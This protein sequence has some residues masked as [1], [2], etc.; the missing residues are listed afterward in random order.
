MRRGFTLI[1]VLIVAA[2]ICL[3]AGLLFPVLGGAR[4][5]GRRLN[6]ASNLHQ[7]YLALQTYATANRDTFPCIN[8]NNNGSWVLG[9]L[10]PKN[11]TDPNLFRCPS[12]IGD[13]PALSG[14]NLTKSSYAYAKFCH[15]YGSG[16]GHCRGRGCPAAQPVP[17]HDHESQGQIS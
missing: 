2:I 3:L 17:R 14:N 7:I 8:D 11:V 12:G 4:E 5:R 13:K 15:P 6:C 10:F 16:Q 9:L 1:E